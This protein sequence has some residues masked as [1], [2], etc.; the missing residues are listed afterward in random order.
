MQLFS[1]DR[2]LEIVHRC[3]DGDKGAQREVFDEIAGKMMSLCMRYAPD[4]DTAQDML[5]D[6]F[7]NLFAKMH[8][9]RGDGSFEGW[10]RKIF[11]TTCLMNL[12]RKD[13]LKMSED[14]QTAAVPLEDGSP[15]PVQKMAYDEIMRLIGCMPEGY[16]LVFNLFVV[17]GF[18]HKEI[19][20]M[21]GITEVTSRSQLNRARMWLQKKMKDEND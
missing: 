13:A 6:G 20:A 17:E 2:H 14:L 3:I 7:V 21:L 4:R 18:T 12:R 15:S 10:A 11:A 5:Q 8:T 1:V 19:A 9:Y 16:R